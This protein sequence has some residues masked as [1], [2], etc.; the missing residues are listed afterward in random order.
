MHRWMLICVL[1]LV[2]TPYS[3]ACSCAGFGPACTEVVSP[4]TAAVFLGTVTSVRPSTRLPRSQ[5]FGEMLDVTL[6]VQEGYK[7]VSSKEVIISTPLSEAAC[8]FP[9]K[10]G[11]QYIVYANEHE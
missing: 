2:L 6:S 3:R 5:V 4:K 1:L 11:E 8:G 9:F 10:K 7:G